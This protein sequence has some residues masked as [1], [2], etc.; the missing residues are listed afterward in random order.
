MQPAG[1]HRNRNIHKLHS[2]RIEEENIINRRHRQNTLSIQIRSKYIRR[3]IR[4]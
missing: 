4:K 3:C 1:Q 2:M